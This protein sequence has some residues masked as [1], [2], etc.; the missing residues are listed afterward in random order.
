MKT[1]R[2]SVK[3][4]SGEALDYPTE[5]R[6]KTARHTLSRPRNRCI[7]M[8][9]IVGLPPLALPDVELFSHSKALFSK[10]CPRSYELCRFLHGRFYKVDEMIQQ[11]YY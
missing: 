1:I 2:D 10:K 9:K 11:G 8:K 7:C 4:D 3:H 5:R 6:M